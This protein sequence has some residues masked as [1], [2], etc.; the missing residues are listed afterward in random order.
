MQAGTVAAL[1]VAAGRGERAGA[2]GPKQYRMLGGEPVLRRTVRSFAGHPLVSNILVVIHPDDIAAYEDAARGLPRLLPAVAGGATRQASVRNGLDALQ[3]A[4]PD[5]VLVHDAARPFVDAALIARVIAELRGAD[6]VVP[7]LPVTDTLK[8]LGDDGQVQRTLPRAR[9][10]VAQTPQGFRYR[11]LLEAHRRAAEAGLDAFTDDAAV[12]EWAGLRVAAVGGV[13]GNVKLTHPEDFVAAQARL[14][15]LV[16]RI[17]QGFDVH[18]FAP[19][20][21]VWLGGVR[22]PHDRTLSGHSDADVVLHALTDAVLGALAEGDIGQHFAPNDPQWRGVASDRFLA[23]AAERVRVRGGRIDH[24]DATIVCEMPKIGPHSAA[25]QG[26]IAEI[27]GL[28]PDQVA[29]KATTSE[30]LGF[31]GRGEGIAALAVATVRVPEGA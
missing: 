20:N 26:R 14:A 4:A 15:P 5:I 6:G 1:L 30:R 23:F 21:H 7:A 25:M 2:D 12:A 17:G 8:L 9:I 3:E 10:C 18:A 19:G 13:A 24:L 11:M 22:I 29:V 28:R 27:V 31:T 16:T